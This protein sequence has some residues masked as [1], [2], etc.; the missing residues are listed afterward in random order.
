MKKA[1]S[2]L[3]P[4]TRTVESYQYEIMDA[5]AVHSS[6]ERCPMCNARGGDY[7]RTNAFFAA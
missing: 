7:R 4:S 6:A 5:L 1:P 3:N 2:L